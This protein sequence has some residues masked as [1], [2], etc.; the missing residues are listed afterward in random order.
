VT[1]LASILVCLLAVGVASCGGGDDDGPSQQDFAERANDICRETDQSLEDV[2][3]EDADSPEDLADAV[4]KVIEEARSTVDEIADLERPEGE[5]GETA[6]EFVDSTRDQTQQAIPMLEDLR[7]G[8][9]AEDQ[10][11]VQ[12]AAARLQKLGESSSN[13]AARKIGA[14]A[15]GEQ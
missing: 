10:Q 12:D 6:Q 15:C 9:E 1:R 8:L 5:A 7:D 3:P 4:D 13:E 2:A 14:N 11:A